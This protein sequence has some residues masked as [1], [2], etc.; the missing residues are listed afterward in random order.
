[1]SIRTIRAALEGRLATWAATQSLPVAYQ[2]VP[3][4]PPAGTY[5]RAFI[6]P[7]QTHSDDL[8]G[9]HRGYR[10]IWQVNIDAPIGVGPGAAEAIAV[11]LDALYPVN[12]RIGTS[13]I[14]HIIT[15]MST[16]PALQDSDRFTLPVFCQYRADTI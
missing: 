3:F 15:P 5:L 2:N 11:L 4:N 10:G 9:T 8:Q 7:A 16:G 14:V 13:P 1:M 12:L 6:L